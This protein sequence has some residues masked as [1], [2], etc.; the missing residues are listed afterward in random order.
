MSET[1]M[2][3]FDYDRIIAKCEFG[4]ELKSRGVYALV[5]ADTKQ[6]YYIGKHG[7]DCL[8]RLTKYQQL[9]NDNDTRKP[10]GHVWE[11]VLVLNMILDGEVKWSNKKTTRFGT[12]IPN[13]FLDFWV[14][15]GRCY[16]DGRINWTKTR[17]MYEEMLKHGRITAILLS[18]NASDEEEEE[19]LIKQYRPITN[20]EWTGYNIDR[21]EMK[22]MEEEARAWLF[23]EMRKYGRIE[24]PSH[25]VRYIAT[26]PFWMR[27]KGKLPPVDNIYN[28]E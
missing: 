18:D 27:E 1:Q 3:Y 2:K 19:R 14:N 11:F 21:N 13:Y 15:W 24:L 25:M 10:R 6:P 4:E 12:D 20:I 26:P 7:Y 23:S 16:D 17:V 5:Y 28:Y 22:R 9:L 8:S